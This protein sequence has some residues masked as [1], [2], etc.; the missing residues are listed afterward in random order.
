[1]ISRRTYPIAYDK[2]VKEQFEEILELPD[3][4]GQLARILQ[5]EELGSDDIS[6]KA[7]ELRSLFDRYV[8]E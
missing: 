7:I 8:Q 5:I 6:E 1:F 2:W 4:Y 3:L